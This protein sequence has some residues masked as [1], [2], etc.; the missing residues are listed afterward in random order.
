LYAGGWSYILQK[1]VRL[2]YDGYWQPAFN[3]NSNYRT[4]CDIGADFP[5]WKGLS[6]TTLFAY[7]HE[8][9]VVNNVFQNDKILT[10]G[11]TYNF[12]AK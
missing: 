2:Y 7:A 11:F 9:V 3:N 8:N 1:R 4:Q 12:K 5:A 10:F 6:F